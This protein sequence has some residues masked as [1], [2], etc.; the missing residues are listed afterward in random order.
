MVAV[1]YNNSQITEWFEL[2]WK[3]FLFDVEFFNLFNDLSAIRYSAVKT[4]F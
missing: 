4:L 3:G 1:S 2:F